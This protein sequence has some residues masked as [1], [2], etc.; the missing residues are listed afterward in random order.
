MASVLQSLSHVPD[1]LDAINNPNIGNQINTKNPHGSGG[2]VTKAFANLIKDMWSGN[3]SDISPYA[4]KVI[5]LF[6]LR[7]LLSP[8]FCDC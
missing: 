2:V 5:F 8:P 4:I 6:S 3:H 1:V 7:F